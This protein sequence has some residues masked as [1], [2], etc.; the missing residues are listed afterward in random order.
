MR[1]YVDPFTGDELV[2]DAYPCK[3]N[4]EAG[5]LEFTGRWIEVQ[6]DEEDPNSKRQV[7]DIINNQNLQPTTLKAAQFMGWAKQ[8]CPKRKAQL[9]TENKALVQPFMANAKKAMQFV[10][11]NIKEID[12][13]TGASCDPDSM[14]VFVRVD[15]ENVPHI[16]LLAEGCNSEKC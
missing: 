1:L 3:F 16:Y 11:K 8:Y 15:E 9:E 13:Y 12:F 7:I 4:E 6:D 5:M 2:S 10:G 14:L